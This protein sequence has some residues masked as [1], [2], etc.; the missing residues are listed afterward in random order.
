MPAPPLSLTPTFA[1][2]PAAAI[3][4]ASAIGSSSG[5]L[6]PIDLD[7]DSFHIGH[8]FEG[9]T[10]TD[11]AD[12][13]VLAGPPAEREMRLPV[14]GRLVHVHPAHLQAVGKTQSARKIASVN[15]AKE[16]VRRVV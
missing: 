12:A 16:P 10:A 1:A 15:G 7:H 11:S 5:P 4:S 8:L 13:A 9:E 3:R 6:P 2:P 14:V